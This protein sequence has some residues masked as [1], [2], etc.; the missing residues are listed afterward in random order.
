M[1]NDLI[2]IIAILIINIFFFRV[3][4]KLFLKL[5][6]Y[7]EPDFL[8]KIHITNVPLVGGMIFILNIFLYLLTKIF[9]IEISFFNGFREIVSFLLGAI[10]VFLV[11]LYDDRYSLKP[12]TKLILIAIIVATSVNISETFQV[13]YINF[14]FYENTIYLN[15]FGI[16]FT[17]FCFLVFLNAFNM[18]DGINGL[19][20]TYFLICLIYLVLLNNNL[21]FFLFLLL[22]AVIFLFFNFQ[23]KVFLGDS[24]SLLL[25]FILSCIFIKF[26]NEDYIYADQIVLLMIIPGIDMLRVAINRILKKQH[27]FKAD[28]SHLHHLILKKYSPK[29]SYIV[30]ITLIGITALM[31]QIFTSKFINLSQII[32][33][34]II[35][36]TYININ[37]SK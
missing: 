7:D 26:H 18:M 10:L 16:I 9:L 17:I 27:P 11:G 13:N 32:V 35:Y 6:I 12:N 30:I 4:I 20:V 28:Q 1:I 29:V 25:G 3:F 23:N 19:S 33:I 15:N 34:L 8:R 37:K 14:L 5:K 2:L 22:P 36:F 31:S 24:G 21:N